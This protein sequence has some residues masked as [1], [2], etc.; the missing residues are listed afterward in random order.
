MTMMIETAIFGRYGSSC[1]EQGPCY[2][3]KNGFALIPI[4]KEWRW[5]QLL[6]AATLM[7][8][9]YWTGVGQ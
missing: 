7:S 4:T 9:R 6:F 2:L 8:I 5:W 1:V 3:D